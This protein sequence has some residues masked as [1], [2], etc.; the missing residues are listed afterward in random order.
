M[1]YLVIVSGKISVKAILQNKKRKIHAVYLLDSR[2]DK[3]THYIET[4]SKTIPI[5]RLPREELDKLAGNT[6][7]GG[8]LVECEE[9]LSDDFK[10][11]P[12][13]N[14]LSLMLIE[15]VSDPFNLGEIAR[16][17]KSLGFDG[18]ITP[19][20]RFYDNE[21]K[22]IRASAGASESLWWHQSE[23]LDVSL[24]KLKES[25]VRV[26]AAYR[27]DMSTSLQDYAMP[28]KLCICLGGALRGLSASVLDQSD[29]HVRIDYD[30]RVSLSTVGAA[31]VFAYERFRSGGH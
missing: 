8:Y 4:I 24:V 16:T 15:G 14:K 1:G 7:H 29:D 9:R 5:K 21:A 30:A 10:S 26:V 22:L 20:Y 12:Q 19:S 11:L 17:V 6:S 23:D 27:G 3:E 28:D 13:S 18:L 31:T 25:G 2:R